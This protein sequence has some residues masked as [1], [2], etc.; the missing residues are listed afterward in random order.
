MAIDRQS[1]DIARGVDS[2]ENR[3]Q[4]AGDQGI[5][6]GYAVNETPEFMP[7]TISLAHKMVR[8]LA[9][10]RKSGKAPF[11]DQIVKVKSLLN[12][13]EESLLGWIP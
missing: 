10:L 8:E 7:L 12:M 1:P 13:L 11:C 6:F 5:M 2:T 4:G 9:M 3:E